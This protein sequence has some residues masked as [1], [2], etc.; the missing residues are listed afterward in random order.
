MTATST[1]PLFDLFVPRPTTWI[2]LNGNKGNH[3][4]VDHKLKKAWATATMAAAA[5]A[6]LPRRL[7]PALLAVQFIFRTV[8][9]RDAGNFEPTLKPIVDHLVKAL[10]CWPDDDERYLTIHTSLVVDAQHVEGV[11]L[12]AHHRPT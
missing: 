2:V 4:S 8:R 5:N 7:E 6:K 12:V 11:R 10:H 3:W 1:A 9:I